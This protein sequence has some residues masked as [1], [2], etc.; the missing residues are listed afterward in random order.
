MLDVS[1]LRSLKSNLCT[2]LTT[3]I[4]DCVVSHAKNTPEIQYN[5]LL[6]VNT[7]ISNYKKKGRLVLS[8][9]NHSQGHLQTPRSVTFL[10]RRPLMLYTS[11]FTRKYKEIHL[12]KDELVFQIIVSNQSTKRTKNQANMS[13]PTK[14]CNKKLSP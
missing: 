5:I 11:H 13:K 10:A 4:S 3:Q 7:S 12:S 14:S 9:E 8:I 1:F 6:T 2:S